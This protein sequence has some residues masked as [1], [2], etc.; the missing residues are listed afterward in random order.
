MNALGRSWCGRLYVRR[1]CRDGALPQWV[2]PVSWR[3]TSLP[4][5]WRGVVWCVVVVCARG[6]LG[7]RA[8][9]ALTIRP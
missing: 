9:A 8:M 7:V 6:A 2:S 5:V 1:R 3:F 4:Q